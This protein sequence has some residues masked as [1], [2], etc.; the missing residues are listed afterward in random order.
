MNRFILCYGS[1]IKVENLWCL[2]ELGIPQTC[3]LESLDAF[4]GYYGDTPKINVPR[5]VYF[6]LGEKYSLEQITRVSQKVKQSVAYNFDAA[7]CEISMR[8]N[9]CCAIR[10]TDI[11]DYSLIKS[12][13]EAYRDHGMVLK[14]KIKNIENEPGLIKIRKFFRLEQCPSGIYLDKELTFNS[15]FVIPEEISWD[16]LKQHIDL[17]RNNWDQGSF[18]AARAFIYHDEGIIDLIRIFS[19]ENNEVFTRSIRDKYYELMNL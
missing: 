5:F 3:L 17:L 4:P 12:L 2:S 16:T 11:K 18:D 7:F 1:L 15:Y 9:T 10:I 8:N 14:K 19:K 6:V 13:Q